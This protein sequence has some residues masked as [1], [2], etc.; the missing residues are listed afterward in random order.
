MLTPERRALL[1]ER[2]EAAEDAQF[3]LVTGGQA[4]VFVDQNGERIE[5]SASN[6]SNLTK[7]IFL[8]KLQL[9][10]QVS[11]PAQPWM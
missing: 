5:Y 11:G 9:G 1:T 7:Y 3:Q 2:L 4:R 10:F 6:M 8:L